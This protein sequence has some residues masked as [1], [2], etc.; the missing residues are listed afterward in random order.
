MGVGVVK[1]GWYAKSVFI[2][3]LLFTLDVIGRYRFVCV[4]M[5]YGFCA[6]VRAGDS[7]KERGFPERRRDR[8]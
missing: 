1:W 2:E 3:R 8:K 5:Y 4:Y 7:G 6:E